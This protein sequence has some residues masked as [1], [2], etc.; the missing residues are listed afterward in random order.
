MEATR[1]I[2]RQL[3]LRDIGGI[4]VCDFIDMESQKNRDNVLKELR[5]HLR[6]DRARTK[7]F[8]VS[9]LGLVEMTRQRVRPSLFQTLTD[10]CDHCEG[11]GRVYTPSTV[12]RQIERSIRRVSVKGDE[13]KLLIRM[14]PEV[15]LRIMEEE[16]DFI[17]KLGQTTR[18]KLDMRDDPL[19]REDEFRILSGAAQTDVTSRY[20]AA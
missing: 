4:I 13:K 17:R 15:A 5:S 8:E 14:H 7:A 11:T 19:L 6:R 2:A 3:R 9:S 1:E 16:P 18:L 20:V 12:V 10:S